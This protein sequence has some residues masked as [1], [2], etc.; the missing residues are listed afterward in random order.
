M[1]AWSVHGSS[2]HQAMSRRVKHMELGL[3]NG[4]DLGN[5]SKNHR[6]TESLRLKKIP[7]NTKPNPCHQAN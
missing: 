1:T 7:K 6:T 2:S 3:G 4:R 5:G